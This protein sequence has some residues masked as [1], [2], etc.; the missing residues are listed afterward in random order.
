MAFTAPAL[1]SSMI[2]FIIRLQPQVAPEPD[3]ASKAQPQTASVSN[4]DIRSTP[5]PPPAVI[6]DKTDQVL[7]AVCIAAAF[8]LLAL[9]IKMTPRTRMLEE[10][11]S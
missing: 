10:Y 1:L 4:E 5:P 2:P 11:L 9:E 8:L 7:L 6:Y 3:S